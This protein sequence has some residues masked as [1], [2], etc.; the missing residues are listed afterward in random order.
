MTLTS[1]KLQNHKGSDSEMWLRSMILGEELC[2]CRRCVDLASG[3]RECKAPRSALRV[4]PEQGIEQ[5]APSLSLVKD[6]IGELQADGALDKGRSVIGAVLRRGVVR[7]DPSQLSGIEG[8]QADLGAVRIRGRRS[9]GPQAS[10]E[11]RRG[12][13]NG[14]EQVTTGQCRTIAGAAYESRRN[15]T[16]VG[17]RLIVVCGREAIA[18]DSIRYG[19][20]QTVGVILHSCATVS[21]MAN[22]QT[23]TT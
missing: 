11:V 20:I 15:F 14:E 8:D 23:C 12:D 4:R 19:E 2:E 5:Q 21:S 18:L 13:A 17:R 22:R 9:G 1:M 7:F 10:D 16:G 3:Q 6:V